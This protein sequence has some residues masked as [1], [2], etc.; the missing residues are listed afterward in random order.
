MKLPRTARTSWKLAVAVSLT[1]ASSFTG[2]AWAQNRGTGGAAAASASSAGA[3]DKALEDKLL[4]ALAGREM[5][6]LLDYYFKKNNV[7]A[8]RQATIRSIAAWR[9]MNNPNLPAA[10]RRQLLQDG[11]KGI[12][13][14]VQSTKD[15]ELLMMRAGQLI[16]FGMKGQINQI[17][18]FGESPKAQAEL[19]EAAEA[20]MK[21]LDRT[22]EECEAQA[23]A[24]VAG[25]TRPNPQVMAKWQALDD[26]MNTAKYTKAFS[27]YGLALSLDAADPRR[28]EVAEAALTYL[29]E[30]EDPQYGVAA[31][32]KLQMG[33]LNI[34]K[35]DAAAAVA[36][37]NE[38][39]KAP[40]LDKSG[41]YEALLV[42]TLANLTAK[43]ADAAAAALGEV[44]QWVMVNMQGE[45][46]K[47]AAASLGLIDYR[48]NELRAS[49]AK[50]ADEKRRFA[51]A[52]D[53]ALSKVM[54]DNPRMAPRVKQM[55]LDKLPADADLT[56]QET[57]LLQSLLARGV[58]EVIR[59]KDAAPDE[60]GKPV[61]QRAL[62]AIAELQKRKGVREDV[63]DEAAFLEPI[64]WGKLGDHAK[65]IEESLDYIQKYPA[66]KERVSNTLSNALLAA[67]ALR[68]SPESGSQRAGDLIT[69]V[70]KLAIGA[71][72]TEY[73][74]AYGKR[75]SDRS[76]TPAD[77]KAA[78]AALHAVPEKHPAVLHA[79]FYELS[80]LQEVL[81][82]K[83]L[84][85][86]ARRTLVADI[87]KL[88]ADVNKRIDT[89]LATA[90]EEQKPRLRFYKVSATLLAA[91]L[92][93]KESKDQ[94][95]V[96]KMLAGFEETAKGLPQEDK[97]GA[98]ALR[99]RVN[100][101]MALGQTQAAVDE[102][103]KLVASQQGGNANVLFNMIGQMDDAFAKART[104]GDRDAMRQN[105]A[106]QVALITPLIEQTKDEA[107]RN[108]YKQWKAD[109]VLRAA[110]NEEDAGRRS[111]YLAEAQRTFTEL[112]GISQ[113]GTPQFDTMRYK[114]A[115]VSYELKDYK[116]VQQELG[117]LI[118]NRRLG[119]P[120]LREASPDGNDTFREN[121]VY[122]EGLL[123]YMQANWELSKTDKSPQMTE[124][125]N[126]AKDTLK[127]LY[128]NRGKN[129]GGERL[130]DE[131]AKLK[132]EMLPG[133]DETNVTPAA[134]TTQPAQARS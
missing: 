86:V 8:D 30:F 126:N 65:A 122:W 4:G 28:K 76:K 56:K 17:E 26:R 38:A 73:A 99:L 9:E 67:D 11:I 37:F 3:A 19:N 89:A 132:A 107:T 50:N 1:M 117:Q 98:T 40:G 52:G 46:A 23:A 62:Q 18:Y 36:K 58:D 2:P 82:D 85:P 130:R 92:L 66:N 53:A 75:L 121:P 106:A 22:I 105:S 54:A 13:A 97:L 68:K 69:K 84:E 114:L 134:G 87:Q 127:T 10:R 113:E 31:A 41:Q 79:R 21:L 111:Q 29:K 102:V 77:Y 83:A 120:D 103:K 110:R 7:P 128:I 32:V 93:Q 101:Y 71:G 100:A 20:V 104:A 24:A 14:F 108:K 125:I 45:D 60:K 55:M 34:A 96:L 51:E 35:G 118:A 44:R 25:Q 74:F 61:V 72:R 70:W 49:L 57:V 90:T 94:A 123:R 124:A 116:K 81:D 5:D 112:L 12:R 109:L 48:I 133:W 39:S 42:I 119:D 6:S 131:Y 88:A 16:E 95:G 64:F 78:A 63:L 15:T 129:V 33:R 47:F 59:A 80:A 91:D 27:S 43:K 115:L